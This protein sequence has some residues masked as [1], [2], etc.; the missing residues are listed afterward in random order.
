MYFQSK[1]FL[2]DKYVP[3]NDS[4]SNLID[5]LSV[6]DEEA[7]NLNRKIHKYSN[8]NETL[9]DHFQETLNNFGDPRN[10]LFREFNRYSSLVLKTLE[11]KKEE[12]AM[13][14]ENINE[15][16]SI[17]DLEKEKAPSYQPLKFVDSKNYHESSSLNVHKMFDYRNP[18]F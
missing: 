2:K 14:S 17:V 6:F 13:I 18:V 5:K 16:I 11:E 1:F 15:I 3:T 8:V 9:E 10:S 4:K 7:E 12:K